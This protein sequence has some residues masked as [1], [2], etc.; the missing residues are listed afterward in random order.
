MLHYSSVF[1]CAPIFKLAPGAR[2]VLILLYQT[3]G[4]HSAIHSDHKF[5][6]N[7]AFLFAYAE[8]AGHL[9]SK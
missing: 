6:E 2:I 5:Q 1:Q 8:I 4:P 7:S 9:F 3:K